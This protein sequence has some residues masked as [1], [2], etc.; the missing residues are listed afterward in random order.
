MFFKK[1]KTVQEVEAHMSF[2]DHLEAL[3]GHLV[4]ATLAVLVAAITL[5]CYREIIFDAILFA[6]KHADF[7]TYKMLCKLSYFLNM[8]DALCI[9]DFGFELINTT[10]AGQFTMH[11][12]VAFVGGL[13]IAFPYI[14]WELWQFIKPALSS[15]EL[16]Y[17][18]G[19]IFFTTLLFIIGILFGY[20]LISPL[21]INFL[22]TYVVSNDVKNMIEMDS[23]ISTITTITLASGLIFELPMLVYFL[24]KIG[25]VTPEFMRRFRKHSIVVILLVAAIIT[26]SPDITS[27]M[28]VAI[29]IYVLY[30]TSIFI[31][32]YVVRGKERENA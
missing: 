13:V 1:K 31:S 3:R 25:I 18:K 17:S 23:Y 22:G 24:T 5:F 19:I 30:E 9:K 12:W 7:I 11:M 27:Q 16:T 8:G 10:L 6:P 2:L 14:I 21:S 26:P 4:R 15:R 20:F 28:L 29:P 32:A